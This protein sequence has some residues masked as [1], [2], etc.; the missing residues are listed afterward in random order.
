MAQQIFDIGNNVV[1]NKPLYASDFNAFLQRMGQ[2]CLWLRSMPVLA[3][4]AHD[5][6]GQSIRGNAA[7]RTRT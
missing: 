2:D 1:A 3:A 4:A 7:G 5:T 6:L